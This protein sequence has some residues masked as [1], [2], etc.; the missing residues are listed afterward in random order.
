MKSIIKKI[1]LCTIFSFLLNMPANQVWYKSVIESTKDFVFEHRNK[2]IFGT[3]ITAVVGIAAWAGWKFWKSLE[4]SEEEILKKE[5]TMTDTDVYKPKDKKS[6]E[7]DKIEVSSNYYL[8][9]LKKR[10]RISSNTRQGKKNFVEDRKFTTIFNDQEIWNK[11]KKEVLNGLFQEIK[12]KNEP[13]KKTAETIKER[14]IEESISVSQSYEKFSITE[15]IELKNEAINDIEKKILEFFEI[16]FF[17][18]NIFYD[19][20]KFFL[21]G[22]IEWD[23]TQKLLEIL[24]CKE[25]IDK[26]QNQKNF[27]AQ[28]IKNVFQTYQSW[29]P[30]MIKRYIQ[31]KFEVKK[32]PI[33]KKEER[34]TKFS[35]KN[36]KKD[37]L[38]EDNLPEMMIEVPQIESVETILKKLFEEEEKII[39]LYNN[40][41]E[42]VIIFNP[43]NSLFIKLYTQQKSIYR[44]IK[45]SQILFNGIFLKR[46]LI[47]LKE[48]KYFRDFEKKTFNN[49]KNKNLNEIIQEQKENKNVINKYIQLLKKEQKVFEKKEL[50]CIEE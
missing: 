20:S 46:F 19:Y 2:F 22:K 15:S 49:R 6:D 24:N 11:V 13:I 43:V 23:T 37:N 7:E 28:C 45:S 35:F 25:L 29:Y 40:D 41:E 38:P 44:D 48:G 1:A 14:S 9:N 21:L 50:S 47:I 36:K 4:S 42:D 10:K 16:F 33:E 3:I 18:K 27:I 8:N 26:N 34:S 30:E 5:M 32:Q 12:K 17:K 31:N 39:Q